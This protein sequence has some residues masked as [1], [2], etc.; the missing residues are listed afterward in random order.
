MHQD[1]YT[2]LW[3]LL[4]KQGKVREALIAADQG[5]AQ[6]LNDL[7]KLNYGS[8]TPFYSSAQTEETTLQALSCLPSKNT[9]F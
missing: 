7:I 3:R 2:S 1:V 9:I 5:G 8:K 6:A 4:L